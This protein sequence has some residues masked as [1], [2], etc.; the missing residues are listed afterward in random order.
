MCGI[1]GFCNRT[2][3]WEE[4][5][6]R[7]NDAMQ[8]RGPDAE[9]IW[10]DENS[11]VVLGHRRLSIVDLSDSGSQPMI[12][13]SGRFVLSFNGEIYNYKIIIKKMENEGIH[14]HFRGTSDTEVLL[15]AFEEWGINKTL[16]EAKG[17]FA[18]ALYDRKNKEL[19]LMR[20]RV[21]EKP[22]YYGFIGKCFTFASDLNAIAS[23]PGF[24]KEINR[25]VL[26]IYFCHGYIP[27]PY[28]IYKG[29]Y[30]LKPGNILKISPP[31][32]KWEINSYWS[33]RET[34]KYGEEHRFQGS[35]GEA[36][37]ELEKLLRASIREQMVAD[38]PVG[39]FLS[40]GIDSSTIVSLLQAVNCGK[41]KTYT[42]GMYEEEY[43]EA[44]TAREIAAVLGT[45]HTE[46]YISEKDAQAVIPKIPG[47]F[48]EPFADSSQIPTYLVS[49]LAHNEVKVALS[50]DG[51]DEL[52][53]GYN[54][55][56][57]VKQTWESR[58]RIPQC[59][60]NIRGKLYRSSFMPGD[61][62][63]NWL[64]GKLL[65]AQSPEEMY[66]FNL[67]ESK[68]RR[69][70][71]FGSG[72][73]SISDYCH[74]N[75]LNDIESNIML[76]DLLMYHPDDI[77]TKV[78]RSAMANS[79]ETR[80]P[81]LDKDVIEFAWSLP[82]QY[83]KEDGTTKKV[84]R[85]ILYKYVPQELV[86][87]PKK[88][89]SVPLKKWFKDGELREWAETLLLPKKIKDKGFLNEEVVSQIWKEYLENDIWNESI[90]YILIFQQWL[91]ED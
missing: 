78:D 38:V 43:D 25:D 47:I 84:L 42:I 29:I 79:L 8:Y 65:S 49:K 6:C 44:G 27:S 62:D 64:K 21:G 82:M 2:D 12:S 57:W 37:D 90:W 67:E 9:G 58:Q 1:A 70:S 55:Y 86:E 77:L 14:L 61:K 15:K 7:M 26:N 50:G 76:T 53:A 24:K 89:F 11:G 72:I 10:R 33:M 75:Y 46:L 73:S 83:K 3:K 60:Q 30:K 91:Q 18:I 39:A 35:M 52:F 36:S 80:I 74:S 28:S 40:G 71:K 23:F 19:Y 22:L 81:L 69:I 13:E 31:F 5:I 63:K 34:A 85:N 59:L 41:A 87:K 45:K 20:D 32:D 66:L 54:N 48:G 88:G 4:Y 68:N 16:N 51:G 56:T 17:M